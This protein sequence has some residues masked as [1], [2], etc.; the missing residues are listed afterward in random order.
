MLTRWRILRPL[1][2]IAHDFR[3]S[4]F[5]CACYFEEF[6]MTPP[7][8]VAGS[9]IG[10]HSKP[11]TDT[12]VVHDHDAG[13]ISRAVDAPSNRQGRA[14]PSSRLG[15]DHTNGI[16]T[17][18][19]MHA[20]AVGPPTFVAPQSAVGVEGGAGCPRRTCNFDAIICSKLAERWDAN[21]IE[22]V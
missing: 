6:R 19:R 3:S 2:E 22:I 8:R 10:R 11:S 15:S 18:I 16:S 5:Q 14:W 4:V 20:A 17:L 1:I 9:V 12:D 13:H 21:A 7:V